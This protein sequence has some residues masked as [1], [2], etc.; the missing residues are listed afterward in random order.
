MLQKLT[1]RPTNTHANLNPFFHDT[2][3][4]LALAVIE[5]RTKSI[6]RLISSFF[7]TPYEAAQE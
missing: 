7:I 1:K 6:F 3:W 4:L 2:R 5:K